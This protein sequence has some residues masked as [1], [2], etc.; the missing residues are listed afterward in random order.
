M[1]VTKLP[2]FANPAFA[3]KLPIFA[4]KNGSYTKH[5]G[6]NSGLAGDLTGDL[7][8]DVVAKSLCYCSNRKV[9]L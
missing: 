8:G 9:L 6:K 5:E 7:A 3:T 4:A 1:E 2:I